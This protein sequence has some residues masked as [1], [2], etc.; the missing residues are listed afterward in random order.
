MHPSFT[1]QLQLKGSWL[2]WRARAE[3]V[4]DALGTILFEFEHSS[5]L[6]TGQLGL[7]PYTFA[8]LASVEAVQQRTHQPESKTSRDMQHAHQ[9]P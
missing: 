6:H 8:G 7:L 1:L 2:D 3:A 4:A 5:C 9:G